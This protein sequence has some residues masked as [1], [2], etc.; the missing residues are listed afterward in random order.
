MKDTIQIGIYK[1]KHGDIPPSV[2]S[3]A[4][5]QLD[6]AWPFHTSRISLRADKYN[7]VRTNTLP[8]WRTDTTHGLEPLSLHL[9]DLLVQI[10]R[11]VGDPFLLHSHMILDLIGEKK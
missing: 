6:A 9:V 7:S 3:S 5:H 1:E 11:P 8:S 2:S 4:P 10:A